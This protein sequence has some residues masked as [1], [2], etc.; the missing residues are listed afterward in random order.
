MARDLNLC[1]FIGRL[2]KDPEVNY[3]AD[4]KMI[5][6]CS[7]ATGQSWNDKATGQKQERTEWVRIVVFGKLAEIFEKYLKKGA[8][9]YISG[10]MQ[11]RKWQ[12]KEGV[13]QYTTEIVADTM[14]M[15][16]GKPHTDDGTTRVVVDRASPP[17]DFDDVIPF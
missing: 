8:Q 5:V 13:D 17:E 9:I 16:G 4:G 12:N 1:Q 6:N 11:T 7:I 3:T 15:L 10:R 2:G 14:Q